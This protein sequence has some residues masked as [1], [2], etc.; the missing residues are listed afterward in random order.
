M[1]GFSNNTKK[2]SSYGKYQQNV[3][4]EKLTTIWMTIQACDMSASTFIYQLSWIII[5]TY[6]TTYC[7]S[8]L[9]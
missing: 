5:P 6:S 1:I 7:S 9:T 8:L 2:K 4:S 3:V